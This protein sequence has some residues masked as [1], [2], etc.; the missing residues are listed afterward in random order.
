MSFITII[1]FGGLAASF[2][3]IIEILTSVL[4]PVSQTIALGLSPALSFTT[5]LAFLSIA[6]IEE[7]SKYIFLRQYAKRFLSDFPSAITKSVLLGI[8]FGL[9]FAALE[10]FLIWYNLTRLPLWALFGSA[11][12]HIFTSVVFTVF[13]FSVAQKRFTRET[14]IALAIFS[15]L[16]YNVLVFSQ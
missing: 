16:L 13:L 6:G 7:L 5:F 14:L 8:S 9:G 2:S 3:L 11:G 10:I 12:L 15:H 4:F 1:L